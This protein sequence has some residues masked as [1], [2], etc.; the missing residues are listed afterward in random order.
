M[1]FSYKTARAQCCPVLVATFS[2]TL[3]TIALDDSSL[4]WLENKN[5]I[6]DLEGPSF[7]SRTV[8]HRR[9]DGSR[10]TTPISDLRAEAKSGGIS[11]IPKVIQLILSTP[12]LN[13][14]SAEARRCGSL[15]HAGRA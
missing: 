2:Q 4:P 14:R 3:T 1:E 12:R 5:L 9:T 15:R 10:D 7:I 11:P 6:A 8:N 13:W